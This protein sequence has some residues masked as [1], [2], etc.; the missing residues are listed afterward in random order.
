[1][2]TVQFKIPPAIILTLHLVTRYITNVI[3]VARN[4]V[5]ISELGNTYAEAII[6]CGEAGD[7]EANLRRQSSG[8]MSRRAK[9]RLHYAEAQDHGTTSRRENMWWERTNP[10][11]G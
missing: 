4:E 5:T 7:Y 1:M 6:G 10:L 3:R 9:R 2:S 8:H 11:K